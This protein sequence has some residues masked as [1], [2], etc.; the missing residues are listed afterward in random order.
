MLSDRV[1]DELLALLGSRLWPPHSRLPSELE[2]TRRFAVSRPILRQALAR[3]RAEGR[4]DTRKGSGTYV[5]DLPPPVPPVLYGQLGSIPE[6]RSF[7]DFRCSLESE[8]AA[9]AAGL[10]DPA[11][12]SRV[13]AAHQRLEAALLAGSAARDEDVA[14]H[15]AIAEATRNRFFVT[16]LEALVE[17]M[18][19]S[20][21]LTT[22]LVRRPQ[23]DSAAE[24]MAEHAAIAEAI[25]ARDA[26]AARAAMRHHLAS[27]IQRLFN[28]VP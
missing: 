27:G 26:D 19:F 21:H 9:C 12:L 5:R 18:K 15:L 6:V 17:Q 25:A 22:E 28:G 1:Y 10:A 3:L 14:F 23:A 24:V 16:T 8:A 13:A 4:I 2:L 7:M 20:M 11:A